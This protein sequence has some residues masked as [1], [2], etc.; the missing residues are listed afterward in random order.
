MGKIFDFQ[1]SIN[2]VN[3]VVKMDIKLNLNKNFVA[4]MNK[5]REKYGEEF[6]KNK[7]VFIIQT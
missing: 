1:Q 6:E 2:W 4:C 7:W 3:G 5:L